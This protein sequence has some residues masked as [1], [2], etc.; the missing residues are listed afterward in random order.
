VI[1][2]ITD[3]PLLALRGVTLSDFSVDERMQWAARRTTKRI[4]DQAYCLLGI[5]GVVIAPLY[6]E[7]EN[8]F[9]RLRDE[10]SRNAP[11]NLTRGTY[12]PVRIVHC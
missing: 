4:E 12:L 10:I 5:F 8:A 1:H 3:I 6:G 2:E 9:L 11:E 7:R